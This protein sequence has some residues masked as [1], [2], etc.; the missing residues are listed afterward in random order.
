MGLKVVL[1]DGHDVNT[2]LV[3]RIKADLESTGHTPWLD[4]TEITLAMRLW[5]GMLATTLIKLADRERRLS[6]TPS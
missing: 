2:D 6:E 1:S 4:T 5:H 3:H